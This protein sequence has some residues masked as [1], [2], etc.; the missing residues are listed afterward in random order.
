MFCMV[1]VPSAEVAEILKKL[2]EPSVQ[3]YLNEICAWSSRSRV[4]QKHEVQPN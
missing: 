4:T 2:R 3:E 1:S